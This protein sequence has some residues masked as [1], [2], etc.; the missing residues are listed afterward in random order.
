MDITQKI[1]LALIILP[2]AIIG[3]VAIGTRKRVGWWFMKYG[4]FVGVPGF[5]LA[6]LSGK[7]PI[8]VLLLMD[9]GGFGRAYLVGCMLV[10]TG[11]ISLTG[12]SLRTWS[13]EKSQDH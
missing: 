2:A 8:E 10:L 5:L 12:E 6:V 11:A 13:S 3:A 1:H 9:T 4:L 7:Q